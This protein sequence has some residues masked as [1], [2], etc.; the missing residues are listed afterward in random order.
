MSASDAIE[1]LAEE[2]LRLV[3]QPSIP[4]YLARV[5]QLLGDCIRELKPIQ[6]PDSKRSQKRIA[7]AAQAR[8]KRQP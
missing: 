2:Y 3:P 4:D 8:R 5:S 1:E 6:S 7:R